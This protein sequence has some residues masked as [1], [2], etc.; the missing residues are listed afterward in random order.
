MESIAMKDIE[1][2][3]IAVVGGGPGGLSAAVAAGRS[4]AKVVLLEREGCL[5][6]G[7]T[8]MLVH[9]FMSHVARSSQAGQG[10]VVSAGIFA[11]VVSRLEARGSADGSRRCIQFEDEAMKLVLDELVAEAGVKVIFHAAMFDSEV[12]S[13][14][15]TS[16]RF[17]HNGGPLRVKGKVFVDGTGDSLLAEACGCECM[18]GNEAG[19]VMP[20][21]MN[22]MIGGVKKA[23]YGSVNL[24]K[25]AAAG[26][27]DDPP[28]INTNVSCV[29]S[30][31]EGYMHFNAIRT[32]G[33]T[34]DPAD[35]SRCEA[36]GRM[37]VANFVTWLRAK[38]PGFEE[39]YLAK[40]ANHVG[41]RESRRVVGDYL[42][43]G[44]DF[45]R[46]AKFDDG[47]A[48]CS[49]DIDIHKQS[50]G[51]TQIEHMGPGEYYQ[52]PYR[53]LT[54]KGLRNLLVAGRG[55]SAD[56]EAH[57]SLRIMPTVMCIGQA[58]GLAAVMSL[59]DGDVRS[60][61]VRKLRQAIRDGGGVL[62]PEEAQ[63]I[64][65]KAK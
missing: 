20:M 62:E 1:G 43:T 8:T 55:V 64:R 53:C 57:S 17:A 56:V 6:G 22:F 54:A 61:D 34:L 49:Y 14:E 19:Q 51:Q 46:A 59:P 21:T 11:E 13:G 18:F 4:G 48:C 3:D 38:V 44:D 12:D 25:L 32:P 23:G 65:G 10:M 39:C 35:L 26:G 16:A 45:R 58:A 47:I 42:L 29:S 52:I 50:Q 31:R 63:W 2:F 24:R 60:V 27:D 33:N 40:T 28:L 41:I 36:E 9:P 15:V 30:P 5:G 37:R 7:A